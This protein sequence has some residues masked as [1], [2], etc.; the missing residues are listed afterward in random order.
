MT[1]MALKVP[2][3]NKNICIHLMVWRIAVYKQLSEQD[4]TYICNTRL[5]GLVQRRNQLYS[6]MI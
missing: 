4:I 1:F 5:Q 3:E 2:M 6:Q